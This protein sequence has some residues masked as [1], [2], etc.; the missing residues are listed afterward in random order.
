MISPTRALSKLVADLMLLVTADKAAVAEAIMPLP[1][2]TGGCLPDL[3]QKTWMT[4]R[5]KV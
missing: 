3:V 1:P 2:P 5:E 4:G